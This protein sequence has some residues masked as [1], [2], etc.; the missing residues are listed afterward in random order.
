MLFI[1]WKLQKD[2]VSYTIRYEFDKFFSVRHTAKV[3][4][5]VIYNYDNKW[6][7]RKLPFSISFRIQDIEC[8][9]L[10][11]SGR[12]NITANLYIEGNLVPN[13]ACTKGWET[14]NVF[15]RDIVKKP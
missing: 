15:D 8:N 11:Y 9:L 5:E 3:N 1:T 6:I 10:I 4:D 2:N 13:V 14:N 7:G 12:N